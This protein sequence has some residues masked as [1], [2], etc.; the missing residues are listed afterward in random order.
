MVELR[1]LPPS[2]ARTLAAPAR[3]AKFLAITTLQFPQLVRGPNVLF[4]QELQEPLASLCSLDTYK[5]FRFI[6][7]T[8]P[9]SST[10]LE[11]YRYKKWG[12]EGPV[13]NPVS[14]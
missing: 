12:R 5:L 2:I 7:L 11:C 4:F 1:S 6:S 13:E 3:S 14:F 10:P 8:D 9:H